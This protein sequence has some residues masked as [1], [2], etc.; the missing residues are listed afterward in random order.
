MTTNETPAMA[1]NPKYIVFTDWDGTVTLQDSNDAMTD[2]LGYGYERRRWL[3]IEILENRWTFR[4]AFKDMLDSITLPFDKCIEYL[5]EHVQLDPG[6]KTF[7]EWCT[8][9]N[10]PVIVVSSGMK[11]VIAALL[12]KLLGKEAVENIE[13]VANDVSVDPETGA[14]DIVFRD[15]TPFGHDKS[16]AIKPYAQLPNRP[17]LFYCGDGVSDLSAAKETDLLFAK[18]GRDLVDYCKRENIPYE[19]FRNFQDIQA[20]IE[21]YIEN[22]GQLSATKNIEST[23]KTPVA[24]GSD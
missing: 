6:F 10:I 15:E 11:P 2:N 19:T 3:N 21:R 1:T 16:R 18:E 7:Y 8:K 13:I 23:N 12:E 24:V 14:W 4:D 22:D 9:R 17:A 5:L 20:G